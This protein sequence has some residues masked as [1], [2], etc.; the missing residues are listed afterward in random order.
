MATCKDFIKQRKTAYAAK[1][2]F[3]TDSQVTAK[4]KRI[5]SASQGIT[6]WV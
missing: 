3:L 4:L 6:D 5:W 2:P 1:F